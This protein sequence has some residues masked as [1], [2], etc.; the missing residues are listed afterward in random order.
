VTAEV[1]LVCVASAYQSRRG[2]LLAD[3]AL[4]LA[5]IA[6]PIAAPIRSR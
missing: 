5:P 3:A 6:A 2:N 4:G 1:W